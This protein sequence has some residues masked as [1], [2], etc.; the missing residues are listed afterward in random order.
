M[1]I[2]QVWLIRSLVRSNVQASRILV[3][4]FC[5]LS[6]FYTKMVQSERVLFSVV[7]I[8][9]LILLLR[10]ARRM[11]SLITYLGFE[12]EVSED[13][14]V[15]GSLITHR[16]R[17]LRE[18]AALR[19]QA[20]VYP[21][22]PENLCFSGTNQKQEWRRPFGTGLVRHC[23]QGLFSPFFTFLRAIYFSPRL[24]FSSSP[25]SAPGSPRMGN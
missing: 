7:N 5:R 19:R 14:L 25:L 21:E 3:H 18:R 22:N 12:Y 23:L 20:W 9:L 4:G 10:R 17:T 11:R 1:T 15:T 6:S 8:L 2:F 16:R 13:V 24:D